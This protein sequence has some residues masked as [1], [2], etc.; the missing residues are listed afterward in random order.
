ME[1]LDSNIL[2][3]ALLV[4]LVA[5]IIYYKKQ[6]E[7][8]SSNVSF[9]PFAVII[10][11]FSVYYSVGFDYTGNKDI[12]ENFKIFGYLGHAEPLYG[13]IYELVGERYV[14][15]RYVVW[16][17]SAVLVWVIYR[18]LCCDPALSIVTF[19]SLPLLNCFYFYRQTLAI[20]VLLTGMVIFCCEYENRKRLI[21][22]FLSLIL[23]ASSLFLHKS[24]PV[25]LL[26]FAL[27]LCLPIN[28]RVVLFSLLCFPILY[29]LIPFLSSRFLDYSF[30]MESTNTMGELY[31]TSINEFELNIFGVLS[32]A[33]SG[34]PL[35]F[36]IFYSIEEWSTTVC[37]PSYMEKVLLKYSYIL[38]YVSFLFVGQGSDFIRQRFWN[39]AY[40]PITF[41]I[42]LFLKN[43]LSH[44]HTKA[45]MLFMYVAI[46]FNIVFAISKLLFK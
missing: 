14:L 20:M 2:C 27:S 37:V 4:L 16:G 21:V 33:I 44:P 19:L 3:I 17:T 45:F 46:Y 11:I 24:M 12:L 9:L 41:F 10:T 25:Y 36:M 26:I 30:S 40:L 15:W 42:P 34:L 39:T 23:I 13:A 22:L 7:K 5:A 31:L 43:R 8:A 28:R 35:F 38:L 6:F 29:Y 32:T 1:A 18:Y